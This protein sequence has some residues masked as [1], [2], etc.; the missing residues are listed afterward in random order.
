MASSYELIQERSRYYAFKEQ[1]NQASSKLKDAISVATELRKKVEESYK[2]DDESGDHQAIKK[3]IENMNNMLRTIDVNLIPNVGNRINT[4]THD[5][6]VAEY[7]E[8]KA[9]E[10]EAERR[11]RELENIEIS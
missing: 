9:A 5:I 1:L 4:L 6:Q 7:Y 2:V 11:R 10:E 3:E 8:Q